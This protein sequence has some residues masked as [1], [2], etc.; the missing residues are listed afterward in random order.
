MRIALL[1]LSRAI[2]GR[3]TAPGMSTMALPSLHVQQHQHQA[4]SLARSPQYLLS[5]VVALCVVPADKV[6]RHHVDED[7][8]LHPLLGHLDEE[9]QRLRLRRAEHVALDD[10]AFAILFSDQQQREQKMLGSVCQ[11]QASEAC[12][13]CTTEQEEPTCM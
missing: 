10:V 8:L 12:S 11:G 1:A 13:S 7:R 2:D 4:P 3:A 5:T 6:F 9:F